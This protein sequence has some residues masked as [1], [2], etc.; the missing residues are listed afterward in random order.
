MRSRNPAMAASAAIVLLALLGAP[1]AGKSPSGVKGALLNTTCPG[2]CTPTPCAC[3]PPP[4]PPCGATVCPERPHP[5]GPALI[6]CPARQADS[7]TA[8]PQPY[9][10]PD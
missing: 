9:S 4:C 7:A 5:Q 1:A 3:P 8:Q 6:P 2:P 10:G